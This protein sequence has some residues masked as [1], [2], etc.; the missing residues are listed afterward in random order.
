[1]GGMKDQN[2][3]LKKGMFSFWLSRGASPVKKFGGL[4]MIGGYDKNYFTGDLLWVPIKP[5][6]YGHITDHWADEGGE[7]AHPV[8][9]HDGRGQERV[10][11]VCEA[12]PRGR[13][14]AAAELQ[15]SGQDVPAQ[16]FRL[17]LA[18]GRW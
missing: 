16:G 14:T 4:L 1:M 12:L 17:L 15:D 6:G 18:H 9:E 11:R 7:Y 8:A 3:K 2:P 10:R 13:E 5:P